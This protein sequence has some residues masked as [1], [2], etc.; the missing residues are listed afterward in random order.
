MVRKDINNGGLDDKTL[1]YI[2]DEIIGRDMYEKYK[3]Q[4]PEEH[5]KECISII[6]RLELIL[7]NIP[8]NDA[9]RENVQSELN[10]AYELKKLLEKEIMLEGL[11]K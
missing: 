3:S 5:Y 7:Y 1:N 10:A 8:Q 2:I 9:R 11:K 4:S 6:K